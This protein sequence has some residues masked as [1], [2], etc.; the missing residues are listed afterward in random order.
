M[1]Q[2]YQWCRHTRVKLLLLVLAA[3]MPFAG[4]IA[5]MASQIQERRISEAHQ[6]IMH[7]AHIGVGSFEDTISQSR[8]L[9]EIMSREDNPGCNA[10]S[11]VLARANKWID[12]LFVIDAAGIVRCADNPALV[13]IDLSGGRKSSR[14]SPRTVSRSATPSSARRAASR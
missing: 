1:T 9:L 12:G 6:R 5:Y 11:H 4:F 14:P 8:H 7:L 13:G 2:T 10:A 3:V